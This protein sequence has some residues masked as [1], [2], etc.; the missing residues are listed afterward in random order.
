VSRLKSYTLVAGLVIFA[1]SQGCAQIYQFVKSTGPYLT[2]DYKDILNRWTREARIYRGL[3][4]ELIVSVTFKSREFRLA[5]AR[6]FARAYRLTHQEEKKLVRDQLKAADTYHD[7]VMAAYV[8]ENRLN[9][10]ESRTSIW[11]IYLISDRNKRIMPLEVA[12]IKEERVAFAHFFPYI[13]PWRI[14]YHIRFPTK[15]SG[16]DIIDEKA[17]KIKL[18]ITSMLGTAELV[19]RIGDGKKRQRVAQ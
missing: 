14:A 19:W 1:L 15:T 9:D 10:F 18:V 4:N 7:F 13:T 5:Y 8:P 6:E 17:T 12:R 11:K 2:E 3:G 16:T